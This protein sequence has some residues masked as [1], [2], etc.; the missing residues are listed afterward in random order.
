MNKNY[1]KKVFIGVIQV[2]CCQ[3]KYKVRYHKRGKMKNPEVGCYYFG[4]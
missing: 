3:S 4:K 2:S 1:L